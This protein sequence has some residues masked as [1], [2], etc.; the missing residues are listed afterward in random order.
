MGFRKGKHKIVK[1]SSMSWD[2]VCTRCEA[3]MPDFLRLKKELNKAKILAEKDEKQCMEQ[4][5]QIGVSV[6]QDEYFFLRAYEA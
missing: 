5:K 1:Q 4:L 3:Q 2:E 6:V